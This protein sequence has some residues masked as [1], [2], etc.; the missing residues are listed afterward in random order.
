MR[1][2]Q[3]EQYEETE[4]KIESGNLTQGEIGD[5]LDRNPSFAKWYARRVEMRASASKLRKGDV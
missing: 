5:L 3:P 1:E 4:A 2:I